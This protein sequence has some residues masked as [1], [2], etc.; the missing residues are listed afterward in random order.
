MA[1]TWLLDRSFEPDAL[2]TPCQAEVK[3]RCEAMV[4]AVLIDLFRP[5]LVSRAQR[6]HL[7]SCLGPT[8]ACTV[9]RTP[10]SPSGVVLK[11]WI[12]SHI[13]FVFF[14][15]VTLNKFARLWIRW[16]VCPALQFHRVGVWLRVLLLWTGGWCYLISWIG[17]P[18]RVWMKSQNQ[19]VSV[20]L[21]ISPVQVSENDCVRDPVLK[22]QV[23]KTIRRIRKER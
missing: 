22:A 5:Y 23:W 15:T 10:P 18:F 20:K 1:H 4:D 8:C 19:W 14:R 7:S 9:F 17:P 2:D 3:R 13:C 12:T 21:A 16:L 6:Y 11:C